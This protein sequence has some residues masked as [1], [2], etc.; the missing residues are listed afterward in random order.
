M[1]SDLIR[2]ILLQSSR[3]DFGIKS[4][5]LA[6]IESLE[7]F[8]SSQKMPLKIGDLFDVMLVDGRGRSLLRLGD[9]DRQGP[10]QV[11]S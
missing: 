3:S 2:S 5:F 6:N 8:I 7:G 1:R 11:R 10:A 4:D 9:V